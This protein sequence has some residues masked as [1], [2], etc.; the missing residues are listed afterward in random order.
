LSLVQRPAGPRT[1]WADSRA[2]DAFK[3]G[4]PVHFSHARTP[5]HVGR[6][7]ERSARLVAHL[8]IAEADPRLIAEADALARHL[9]GLHDALNEGGAR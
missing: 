9:R 1:V 8:V 4:H 5:A 2:V 7:A 3:E 6:C